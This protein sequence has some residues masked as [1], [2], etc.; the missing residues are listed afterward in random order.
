MNN[1][2]SKFFDFL[3]NTIHFLK[4][5][6]VFCIVMHMLY[7]IQV[8]THNSWAWTN[9]MDPVINLILSLA[10]LIN[11]N[12]AKVLNVVFEFKYFVALFIYIAIYF[13]IDYFMPIIDAMEDGYNSV[14]SKVRNIKEE[15]YNKSLYKKNLKEQKKITKYYI[16][17][18]TAVK[19]V[20]GQLVQNVDIDEQNKVLLKHLVNKTQVIP[21]KFEE[22]F[23]FTYNSFDDIDNIL[24]VFSKLSKTKAPLDFLV[25][26]QIFEGSQEQSFENI[27]K[28]ASLNNYNKITT[29]A[30][31][32]FRYDYNQGQTYD[33]SQLGVYQKEGATFELY[34]FVKKVL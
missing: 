10:G 25:C 3:R 16:Y 9:V 1:S 20:K 4:I 27:R 26:V 23:L 34:E 14:S 8:L 29:M 22:G 7:W 18:E 11:S 17:L 6:T 13:V 24:D 5:F 15:N 33:I 21:Q 32:V 2:N 31:T 30:D 12:S 19:F 28:M